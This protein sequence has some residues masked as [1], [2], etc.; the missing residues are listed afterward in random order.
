[1]P[2]RWESDGESSLSVHQSSQG[3]ESARGSGKVRASGGRPDGADVLR[4]WFG[5]W[6]LE[7]WTCGQGDQVVLAS[8][9]EC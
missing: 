2:G 9:S 4:A 6:W 3:L 1:M 7:E 5:R 8:W